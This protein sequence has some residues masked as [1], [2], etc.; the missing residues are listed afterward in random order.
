FGGG[1]PFVGAGPSKA[2]L[3][4]ADAPSKLSFP[5]SLFKRS[6][7]P[8]TTNAGRFFNPASNTWT[9]SPNMNSV[10]SFVA[11]G[12]I[13]S[14]LIIAA[15]GYN[16]STTV[17]TAETEG[18][19]VGPTP[20]PTATATAS[21]TATRTPTATPTATATLTPTPT[22]TATRTPTP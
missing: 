20:T 15:G 7:V 9:A 14:S 5:W 4:A 18:I 2:G 17:A 11:G 16:G 3:T 10:R 22:P 19:C 12:A 1:N 21:P 8:E 13:G 6:Q